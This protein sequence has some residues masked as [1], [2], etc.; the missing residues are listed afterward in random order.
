MRK[1]KIV[2]SFDDN[3]VYFG[4]TNARESWDT[5]N[6][7]NTIWL[8]PS[9]STE[10][11]PPLFDAKTEQLI[12]NRE[13]NN[14]EIKQIPTEDNTPKP[15]FDAITHEAVWYNDHWVL[16]E[17]PTQENT[18][19]PDFDSNV[20]TCD[21]DADHWNLNLIPTW[22]TVRSQRDVLLDDSDWAV[23]P[24]ATPKPS[25]EAWLTYRQALRDVPQTFSTP[26]EVV[27]PNKP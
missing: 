23:M 21:W 16:V 1:T 3:G 18:P 20:Y 7:D 13:S 25:K 11:E 12:F 4:T 22:D 14:W 19:K 6:T 15:D 5:V 10:T 8:L 24:D 26:E 27:W 17:L 2:Y 9:N